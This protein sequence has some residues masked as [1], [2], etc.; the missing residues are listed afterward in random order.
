[1]VVAIVG[2][3]KWVISATQLHFLN[4]LLNHTNSL[5]Y[6]E[7]AKGSTDLSQ[8]IYLRTEILISWVGHEDHSIRDEHEAEA[9]RES[10]CKQDN[11]PLNLGMTIFT[12]MIIKPID[13]INL[14]ELERR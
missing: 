9:L 6:N 10:I 2:P 14:R 8:S 13:L 12:I 4:H 3:Y 5:T 1:M 11:N 7:T